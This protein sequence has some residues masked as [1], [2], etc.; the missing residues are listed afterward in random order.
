VK[1][2]EGY[3]SIYGK[4][5]VDQRMLI[6]EDYQYQIWFLFPSEVLTEILELKPTD[7]DKV[8]AMAMRGGGVKS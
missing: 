6:A 7:G 2:V 1:T 5:V 4:S 8:R 3:K